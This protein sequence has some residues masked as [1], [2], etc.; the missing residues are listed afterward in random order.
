MAR[1]ALRFL[2]PASVVIL[3]ASQW[4]EIARYLKISQMSRGDGHPQL[5][6]AAGQHSY[7]EPPGS[8][9]PDGTGDFDSASRGGGPVQELETLPGEARRSLAA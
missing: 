2:L 3:A 9:T 1:K 4:R 7:P 5:V 6:P 8:G